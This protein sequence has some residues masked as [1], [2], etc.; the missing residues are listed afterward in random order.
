MGLIVPGSPQLAQGRRGLGHLGLRLWLAF[1]IVAAVC[2]VA[3]FVV[4]NQL[5]GLFATGWFLTVLAGVSAVVGLIGLILLV[6]TWTIARPFH[7]GAVRGA[8]FTV[9]TV[10]LAAGLTAGTVIV[11]RALAASGSSLAEIFP[12]GGDTETNHG[13]YNILLLG[14]DSGPD[15]EGTRPDSI[16]LASVDAGTGRT[17]LFSLPRNLEDVPFPPSSPLAAVYPHGFECEEDA[18]MLNAVYLAG[19]EHADLYQGAADPGAQAM[20]DAVSGVTGLSINY[21]AMV[22]MAGFAALIDAVGGIDVTVT[23]PVAVG[24]E[25]QVVYTID[26]GR[27]HFTGEEAL[28]FARTRVDSDDFDRMQRQKC[29]MAAMLAQLNPSTVA[30]RFTDL[31]QASGNLLVTSVPQGTP[32]VDLANLALEA[33]KWPIASVSFTPPLIHPGSPDFTLIHQ[34]VQDEIARSL[35]LDSA[36]AAAES[37]TGD[38]EVPDPGA[39]G[40]GEGEPAA[41]DPGAEPTQNQVDDLQAICSA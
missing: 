10:A 5:M 11:T 3:F 1:W 17:I 2:V 32:M 18:C 40:P 34:V 39:G 25:G 31:A 6:N 20:I 29:V 21:Y 14:S 35:A 41:P 16:T 37:P 22:N 19:L 38:P 23:R 30:S 12:G 27:H 7:M 28:W 36:T 24:A 9:I 13:R 33:R 26:P 4:R 15:R 8:L